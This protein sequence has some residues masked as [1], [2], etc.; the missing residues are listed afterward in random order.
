MKNFKLY[1]KSF[2]NI[3]FETSKPLKEEDQSMFSPEPSKHIKISKH[4]TNP[5]PENEKELY[6]IFLLSVVISE[7]NVSKIQQELLTKILTSMNLKKKLSSLANHAQDITKEEVNSAINVLSK[8]NIKEQFIIELLV[9]CQI[10][11]SPAKANHNTL[12][13]IAS[14]L[15]MED[16]VIEDIISSTN[17]ILGESN[18]GN[19]PPNLRLTNLNLPSWEFCLYRNLT[20]EEISRGAS[21]GY[22]YIS[23]PIKSKGKFELKNA[24]IIFTKNGSLSIDSNEEVTIHDSTFINPIIT[25]NG[26][27]FLPDKESNHLLISKCLFSGDYSHLNKETALTTKNIFAKLE[28]CTFTTKNARSIK[29]INRPIEINS[30]SFNGCGHSNLEG[31]AILSYSILYVDDSE[32]SDCIATLGGGIYTSVILGIMNCSF[33]NCQSKKTINTNSNHNGGGIYSHTLLFP[34]MESSF[35]HSNIRIN[36]PSEDL[37]KKAARLPEHKKKQSHEKESKGMFESGLT[38]I[39]SYSDVEVDIKD[40]L[41]RPFDGEVAINSSFTDSHVSTGIENAHLENCEM[42]FKKENK[43]TLTFKKENSD[44]L[45]YEN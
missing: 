21:N 33:T 27:G 45:W 7:R 1:L 30:C 5:L 37:F 9:L 2:S 31:G 32:F 4:H 19:I 29:S 34:I 6:F 40:I 20:P 10:D 16:N 26:N 38:D 25:I 22:W 8:R 39:I 14:L 18:F 13:E 35:T 24:K 17:I 12:S 36:T 3:I 23:N 11:R 42:T 43:K 28:N 41:S 44:H 15:R